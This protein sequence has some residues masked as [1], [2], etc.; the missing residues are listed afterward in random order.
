MGWLARMSWFLS[1][2]AISKV[3][4]EF[5]QLYNTKDLNKRNEFVKARHESFAITDILNK[6]ADL[7]EN[8]TM[9]YDEKIARAAIYLSILEPLLVN[10]Q[11]IQDANEGSLFS[12]TLNIIDNHDLLSRD[13][14]H[15]PV[16]LKYCMRVLASGFRDEIGIQK[17]MS[18]KGSVTKILSIIGFVKDSE[19]IANSCKLIRMLVKD[20]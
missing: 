2:E 8:K 16:Y 6:T 5:K 7:K 11:N 19:I 20:D 12:I 9:S 13:P 14:M 18:V 3:I 17:F 15:P 4:S 10:D 1:P